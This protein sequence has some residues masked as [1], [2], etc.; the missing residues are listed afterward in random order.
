MNIL[1][2]NAQLK[3][4]K[5]YWPNIFYKNKSSILYLIFLSFTRHIIFVVFNVLSIITQRHILPLALVFHTELRE[6]YAKLKPS[7]RSLY[8]LISSRADLSSY[9]LHKKLWRI[10]RQID[11]FNRQRGRYLTSEISSL[12]LENGVCLLFIY[13]L[14]CRNLN[15]PPE[16]VYFLMF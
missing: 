7:E 15:L 12:F 3:I 14:F 11:L 6:N 5:S 10:L 8:L 1:S 2:E 4:K 16:N 13:V 9:K